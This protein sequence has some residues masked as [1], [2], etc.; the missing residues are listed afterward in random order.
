M[1][2]TFFNIGKA[3]AEIERLNAELTAAKAA[4]PDAAIQTQLNEALES[5]NDISAKLSAAT[6][7]ITSLK[8]SLTQETEKNQ[9]LGADFAAVT[10]QLNQA[11]TD[12]NVGT[13]EAVA[14][15]SCADKINGLKQAVTKAVAA[16]G[17]EISALPQQGADG[18]ASTSAVFEQYSKI[19]D[20]G[21]RVAF[22]RKHSAAIDAHFRNLNK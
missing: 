14:A 11:C 17:A 6:A 5:N 9:K 12:M 20:A 2:Y 3:N 10:S 18:K 16:S 7:E 15:M 22:Y 19:T 21:E 13:A 8:A 1:A 4:T